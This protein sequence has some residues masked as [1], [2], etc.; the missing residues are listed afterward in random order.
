MKYMHQ[1]LLL[2][3]AQWKFFR[4]ALQHFSVTQPFHINLLQYIMEIFSFN[5]ME[6]RVQQCSETNFNPTIAVHLT[7]NQYHRLHTDGV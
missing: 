4:P 2:A 3:A 7:V 1:V 5:P 6:G